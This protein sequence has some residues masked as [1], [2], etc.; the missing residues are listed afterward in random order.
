MDEKERTTE[1]DVCGE[2]IP[3]S[4]ALHCDN[5]G[6]TYCPDCEGYSVGLCEICENEE[7]ED[8]EL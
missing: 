3:V 5:C 4:Q 6:R 8:S 2:I 7:A 1:C